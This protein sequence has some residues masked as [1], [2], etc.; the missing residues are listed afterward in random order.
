M[1][2]GKNVADPEPDDSCSQASWSTL[3][4]NPRPHLSDLT[5]HEEQ[6]KTCV[7]VLVSRPLVSTN[8][9]ARDSHQGA[10]EAER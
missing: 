2:P 8:P 5:S 7:T 10:S 3:K 1:Q 6:I 4:V 9:K